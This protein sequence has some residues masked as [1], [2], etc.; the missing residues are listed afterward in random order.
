[1]FGLHVES[2]NTIELG[3]LK[4]TY[5]ALKRSGVQSSLLDLRPISA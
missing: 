5:S 4:S 1:M 2:G 3:S